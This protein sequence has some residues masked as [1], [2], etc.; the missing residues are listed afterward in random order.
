MPIKHHEFPKRVE[1]LAREMCHALNIDPDDTFS[2]DDNYSGLPIIRRGH[3]RDCPSQPEL[4][5]LRMG[6]AAMDL[7]Q[8]WRRV[9]LISAGFG[10]SMK[11]M[12]F[13]GVFH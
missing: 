3:P 1:M 11:L 10:R 9:A 8:E 4:G 7:H 2:H 5:E 13:R 6:G 12:G